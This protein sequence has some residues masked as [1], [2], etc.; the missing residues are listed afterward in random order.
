MHA[1]LRTPLNCHRRRIKWHSEEANGGQKFHILVVILDPPPRLSHVL[2]RMRNPK[3]QPKSRHIASISETTKLINMTFQ[4]SIWTTKM[5]AAMQYC[6]VITNPRWRTAAISKIA[7]L[8]YFSEQELSY[9]KQIA[10]QLRTSYWTLNIIVTL[11]CGS[12]VT[13]GH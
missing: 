5:C 1:H 3:V 10:R 6:D 9:R 7:K 13:Q 12:E 11:K 4:D 8:P 2:Q